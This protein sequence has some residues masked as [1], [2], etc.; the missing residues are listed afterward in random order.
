MQQQF[1]TVTGFF[2]AVTADGDESFGSNESHSRRRF[3]RDNVSKEVGG[4][5]AEALRRKRTKMIMI[6][7]RF[8][9]T[10][11][12]VEHVLIRITVKYTHGHHHKSSLFNKSSL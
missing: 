9:A 5:W 10:Y 11:S 8:Q 4:A 2:R 6:Y 7:G 3:F 1:L 12:A